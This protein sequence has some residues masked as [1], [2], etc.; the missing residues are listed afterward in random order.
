DFGICI[1]PEEFVSILPQNVKLLSIN[2]KNNQSEVKLIWKKGSDIIIK[3]CVEAI[4]D[5]YIS[6]FKLSEN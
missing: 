3:N 5:S 1:V 2:D 6:D 4:Q